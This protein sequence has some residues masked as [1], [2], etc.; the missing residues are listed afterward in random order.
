M[1]CPFLLPDH[2]KLL[3]CYRVFQVYLRKNGPSSYN[4]ESETYETHQTEKKLWKSVHWI[5]S[6]WS[7]VATTVIY[8]TEISFRIQLYKA[9]AVAE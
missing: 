6:P 9:K 2:L 3:K 8:T 4:I 1:E 5:V 7:E